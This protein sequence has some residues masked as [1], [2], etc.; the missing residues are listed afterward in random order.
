MNFKVNWAILGRWVSSLAIGYLFIV[1]LMTATAQQRVGAALDKLSPS[2]GYSSA[3]AKV[4][5]IEDDTQKLRELKAQLGDLQTAD[6][7][8]GARRDEASAMRDN[9]WIGISGLERRVARSPAAQECGLSPDTAP[10]DPEARLI[11]WTNLADCLGGGGLSGALKEQVAEAQKRIDYPE[12]KT[13]AD[14]TKRSAETAHEAVDKAEKDYSAAKSDIEAAQALKSI[15][16]ELSVLRSTWY[17]AGAVFVDFPPS[18]LQIILAFV[19]GLFGA[20]LVTLILVVYPNTK[21]ATAVGAQYSS[22]LLLGGLISVVV[23]VILGGGSAVLGN[24]NPFGQ[25]QGNYMT[26]CAVGVLA[27]MF[28]DRVAAWLSERANTFFA[29]PPV[30]KP[31]AAAEGPKQAANTD[32]VVAAAPAKLPAQV[33]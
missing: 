20:L 23:Y 7:K 16:D 31:G 5:A 10:T 32:G 19:S 30:E 6:Q 4:K 29:E 27:G 25:S 11:A 15:F 9:A 13:A 8:A 28:S 12:A 17:T 33:G 22:R 26:F 18:L 1:V 14:A 21:L 3:F 24:T 2:M